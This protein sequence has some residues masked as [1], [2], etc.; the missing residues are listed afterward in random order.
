MEIIQLMACTTCKFVNLFFFFLCQPWLNNN[1][2][3]GQFGTINFKQ[4]LNYRHHT[5]IY[6][7]R[8]EKK[9]Q[10][11]MW[12]VTVEYKPLLPFVHQL[13]YT[14]SVNGR[15]YKVVRLFL[16]PL[17][18]HQP[19]LHTSTNNTIKPSTQITAMLFWDRGWVLN[20]GSEPKRTTSSRLFLV[21]SNQS[22]ALCKNRY[23]PPLGSL[24]EIE[25]TYVRII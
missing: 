10:A 4:E 6:S 11:T 22:H 7:H 3:R 16:T 8:I 23:V 20:K 25:W 14:S 15:G 19:V 2:P 12:M 9:G 17:K 24:Q 1:T 13:V 18:L 5:H 21:R